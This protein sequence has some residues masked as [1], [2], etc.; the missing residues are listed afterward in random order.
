[1]IILNIDDYIDECM[2]SLPIVGFSELDRV[3]HYYKA[4][5]LYTPAALS[6]NSP[7]STPQSLILKPCFSSQSMQ[8]TIS[9][10]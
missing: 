8:Y 4:K 10:I 7:A 3:L 5:A 2:S 9:F 6:L 1:M